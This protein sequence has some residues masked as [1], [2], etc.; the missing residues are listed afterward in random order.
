MIIS[1]PTWWKR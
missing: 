1:T